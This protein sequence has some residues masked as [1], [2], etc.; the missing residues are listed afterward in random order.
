MR[1]VAS[2]SLDPLFAPDS[3]AVVG[4]SPDSFYSANLIDNLLDYGFQGAFY[5]VNPSRN[6]A[7]GRECYDAIGD[8]PEVVDLVVVSVPREYAVGVVREAGE[9][10]VP[11]AL[12]ITAGF[13]EADAEGERLQ[14]EL[15]TVAAEEDIRVCGPNCIGL[16]N[17]VDSTVLT[18][19]CSRQPGAGSIGLVS[20]SGALAFTTFFE[21]AADE[22]VDF[23]Y[24]ASTGNEADLT[25]S[26]YVEYMAAQPEVEVIC[27]YVEGLSDPGRFMTVVD[28]AVRAGTPVLTIKSETAEAY[29]VVVEAAS[30]S[31]RES[32]RMAFAEQ[33]RPKALGDARAAMGRGG[34]RRDGLSV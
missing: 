9:L 24:L 23:A 30:N 20:Q 15:A 11:A 28:Q 21:R 27:A 14:S 8:V 26:D 25:V 22:A 17:A 7:W 4:A 34:C 33:R 2:R 19:T 3:I 6:E 5:P 31:E 32:Q 12:I 1:L 18:S 16:A 13:A 29:S 10:G